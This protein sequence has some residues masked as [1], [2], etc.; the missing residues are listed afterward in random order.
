MK[1]SFILASTI[2]GAAIAFNAMPA[3]AETSLQVAYSWGYRDAMHKCINDKF[4][5]QY[6]GITISTRQATENYNQGLEN[7]IRQSLTKNLP[8]VFFAGLQ[9]YPEV[10]VRGL[11]VNLDPFLAKEE[12]L[13][14]QG[15]ISALL[16]LTKVKGSHY[17]LPA[18]VGTPLAVYNL[19]LV[20]KAGGDPKNLPKSWEEA[21]ALAA[22]INN[23]GEKIIGSIIPDRPDDWLF[24]ALV[25]SAG[26][27]ILSDDGTDVGFDTPEGARAMEAMDTM[28][29]KG[30]GVGFLGTSAAQQ[31]FVAGQAGFTFTAGE[32][33]DG[34]LANQ[35]G[36]RFEMGTGIFPLVDPLKNNGMPIGGMAVV[37]VTKD[38]AKQQTAYDYIKFASGPIGQ[39]CVVEALGYPPVT[40]EAHK[41][42][43]VEKYFSEH[44]LHQPDVEQVKTAEPWVA[45]PGKN[46]VK[47]SKAITDGLQKLLQQS[48]SPAN[49][50]KDMAKNV[51]ELI[52][53][54]N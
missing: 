4:M 30:G 48:D 17:G 45:F 38:A 21:V 42:P 5:Q 23:P 37:M 43:S 32:A 39:S 51:R 29:K 35:I 54:Q 10:V 1:R 47:V 46:S 19:D 14:K 41:I 28:V 16:E 3:R 33:L 8:D 11:A 6:P 27:R 7:L 18:L 44:P 34:R 22:R 52:S 36:S 15:Y 20:R 24:Q 2:L 40:T 26:G 25:Y 53:A 31:Q 9:L 13:E 12:T 49:M 50:L